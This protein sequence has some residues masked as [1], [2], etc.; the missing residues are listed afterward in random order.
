MDGLTVSDALALAKDNDGMFNGGGNGMWIVFLLFI[1]L[2]FNG[3]GGLFGGEKSATSGE[4]QRDFNTNTIINKLDNLGNG[5]SEGFYAQNNTILGGFN[6][7]NGA[8]NGLS[9]QMAQCCCDLGR[10]LDS[11]KAEGYRNTCDITTAIHAEGEATRALINQTETQ[12]LRDELDNAR[13]VIANT[14]QTQNILGQLGKYYTN[15]PCYG[16]NYGCG[17]GTVVTQ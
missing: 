16:Y 6:G 10:G 7:V 8:I 5:L 15:P 9:A 17:C 12:R 13:S 3:N 1:I 4:V 2:A 14:V 11:I